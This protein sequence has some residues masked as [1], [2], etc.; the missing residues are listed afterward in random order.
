MKS[1]SSVIAN[2]YVAV[3]IKLS[4]VLTA[5]HVMGICYIRNG[6]VIFILVLNWIV[7][8]LQKIIFSFF[9]FYYWI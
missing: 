7:L 8:I 6:K 4:L 3:N 1:E 9:F 5:R 2:K